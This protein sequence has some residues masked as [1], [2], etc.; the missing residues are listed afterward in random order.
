MSKESLTNRTA[1]YKFGAYLL[2]PAK[3]LLLRDGVALPIAPKT[4]DL[5][6]LLVEGRGR[7]F[8]KKEFMSAL[9]PDSFVEEANLTFQIST[10]RKILDS[11]TDWIDTLPRYGYRFSSEVVE[12]DVNAASSGSSLDAAD[13]TS[14]RTAA[15]LPAHEG[16]ADVVT[17]VPSV[18]QRSLSFVRE[19]MNPMPWILSAALGALA[20]VFAILYFHRAEP[21]PRVVRF[22]IA[23]PD[24]ITMPDAD[25]ITVSPDGARLAFIGVASDGGRQLW[26]RSLDSLNAEPLPG[27]DR[28]ESAFWSPDGRML[29]FFA[30]GKLKKLD[31]KAGGTAQTICATPVGP[32]IGR[33]FGTWNSQDIILFATTERPEIYRVSANG[34][35]PKPITA[36]DSAK[37]ETHHSAPQFLPDGNHFIYFVQSNQIEKTGTYVASLNGGPG[38]LLLT[39]PTSAV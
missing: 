7:V 13:S 6:R 24:S 4:F 19:G 10:L 32:E 31:L 17:L 20:V 35:E 16:L 9:W 23:P 5:L 18:A 14:P 33:A 2:D 28:V 26:V 37:G 11:E 27:T 30:A 15:G 25:P 21:D 8:T 38:S 22:R 36:L 12:I 29:A 34:G 1:Q 3:R 39:S